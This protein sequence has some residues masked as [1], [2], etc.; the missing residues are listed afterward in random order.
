M[1]FSISI[2]LSCGRFLKL[3][4]HISDK[5][6]SNNDHV[7]ILGNLLN[8]C[9][10]LWYCG[11]LLLLVPNSG[12]LLETMF[13]DLKFQLGTFSERCKA[14]SACIPAVQELV[15]SWTGKDPNVTVNHGEV[16]A[17]GAAVLVSYS[18]L[19]IAGALSGDN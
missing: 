15:K 19:L 17:L 4:L 18:P 3:K 8:T 13:L 5:F 9:D 2:G 6:L 11:L 16:V 7:S 12:L 14:R 1:L 10:L